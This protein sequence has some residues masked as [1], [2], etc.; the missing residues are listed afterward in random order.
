MDGFDGV[1]FDG[2]LF[3][4][5]GGLGKSE[6]SRRSVR[7]LHCRQIEGL[8]VCRLAIRRAPFVDISAIALEKSHGANRAI[9]CMAAL[10]CRIGADLEEAW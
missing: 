6:K 9:G 4:E 10:C 2:V 3:D 8:K 7:I 1:M 5:V